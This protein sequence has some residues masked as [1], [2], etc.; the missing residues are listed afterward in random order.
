LDQPSAASR[1]PA[2]ARAIERVGRSRRR[3]SRDANGRDLA[4][5]FPSALRHVAD[6]VSETLH[7]A[8]ERTVTIETPDQQRLN[9]D[10]G[11]G[12]K[13]SEQSRARM[14]NRDGS[15][16]VQRNDLSPFHPYNAYHTVLSA[17]VPRLIGV[18]VAGYLVMNLFFATLYWLLGPDAL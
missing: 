14:V 4:A 17:P 1:R 13:M 2:L 3:R 11:L 12:G 10:L 6:A 16:N 9:Q 18:M 5:S 15:F 8:R 7:H